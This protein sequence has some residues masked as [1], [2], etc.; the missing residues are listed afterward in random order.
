MDISHCFTIL[1]GFVATKHNYGNKIFPEGI[2]S[3]L[4]KSFKLCTGFIVI[5]HSN[6]LVGLCFVITDL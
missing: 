1:I 6:I 4:I 5:T 2:E 3:L